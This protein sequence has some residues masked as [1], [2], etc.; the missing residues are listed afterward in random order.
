VWSELELYKGTERRNAERWLGSDSRLSCEWCEWCE[1]NGKTE[2][3]RRALVVYLS[4]LVAII[5]RRNDARVPMINHE[6]FQT[7]CC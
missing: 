7:H 6:H 4:T 5:K 2:V 3:S 1:V